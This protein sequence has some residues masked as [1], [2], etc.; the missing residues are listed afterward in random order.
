MTTCFPE[1]SYYR[2]FT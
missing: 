1:T 2:P